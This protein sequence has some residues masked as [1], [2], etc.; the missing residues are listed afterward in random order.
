MVI[1]V[2]RL[3]VFPA[4]MAFAASSDNNPF[5][6]LSDGGHFENL[7]LYEMVRRRCRRIVVVDAAADPQYAYGDLENAIRKI[8]IALND[9]SQQS[10]FLQTVV[11]R[12]YRFVASCE[13]GSGEIR[14][15][16]EDLGRAVMAA[17]GLHPEKPK[18]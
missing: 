13:E 4:L 14:F 16:P 2:I 7:G 18:E 3:M 12:G 8:R 1:D 17:A 5:V 15:T 6:Y 10:Q 11:G 9:D